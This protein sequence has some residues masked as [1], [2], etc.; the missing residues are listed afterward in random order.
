MTGAD[1][2]DDPVRLHAVEELGLLGRTAQDRFDRVTRTL[3][4]VLDVPVGLLTLVT[5]DAVAVVAATG[6]DQTTVAREIAFC[7]AV[8]AS[9]EV[10]LVPDAAA[11]RR[12]APSSLATGARAYAGVP[13]RGPG[14]Q[15]VGTLCGLDVRPRAWTDDDVTALVDLS[16]WAEAELARGD[17]E[18]RRAQGLLAVERMKDEL[19]SVVS[20]E[21][22]TPLTSLK[23][24]LGLLTAG[25]VGALSPDGQRL[26]RIALDNA[27][28]LVQLVDE[29]CD[30]E[31]LTAGQVVLERR[32]HALDALVASAVEAVAA[33]AEQAGVA[34]RT[35]VTPATTWLD[36]ARV[37]HAVA[38]LLGNA[39][40]ASSP[41]AVVDVRARAVA[42]GVVLEVEDR[43][44]GI[45]PDDLERVFDSFTRGDSSDSR[46][47]GGTGL[48]LALARS[49]VEAHGGRLTAC[50]TPDLGTT[51]TIA[52]PQ[53]AADRGAGG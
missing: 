27:D 22:R 18:R 16:R 46:V 38:H 12:W 35:S 1:V 49:V 11:D 53:R 19:I 3:A 9:Q 25:V 43:G 15:V 36:G 51:F 7:T 29:I 21:L 33:Q 34:V 24:S 47:H 23:G 20:H 10:L 42:D 2:L 48:G 37:V 13:L 28:R 4:R 30:L 52:L 8:V 14:G 40:R 31:R 32:P 41:G 39:V 6:T 5:E 17:L 26:A 44:C 50:S 45:D